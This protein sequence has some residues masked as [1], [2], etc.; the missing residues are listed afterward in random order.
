[1]AIG[2]D[3]MMHAVYGGSLPSGT[4]GSVHPMH[5]AYQFCKKTG[6]S[7]DINC[8]NN[9]GT[10]NDKDGFASMRS[11]G[12]DCNDYNPDIYPGAEETPGDNIDSNCNGDNDL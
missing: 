9:E 12:T 5:Y 7:D 6:T 8:D 11:G 1:M 10:D 2:S 3:N 4:S